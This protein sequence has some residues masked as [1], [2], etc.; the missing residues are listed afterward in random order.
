MRLVVSRAVFRLG[1]GWSVVAG[2]VAVGAL[3]L[4]AAGLLRVLTA[5]VLA[6]LVWGAIRQVIPIVPLDASLAT[7]AA[8]AA[9]A[10]GI[11]PY[12]Q[13]DAPLA[14]WLAALTPVHPLDL[15]TIGEQAAPARAVRGLTG[16]WQG[17]LLVGGLALILS[18]LLGW[19]AVALTL[20]ALATIW[21]AAAT[22]R[23]GELPALAHALLDVGWPWL[24]GM[25]LAAGALLDTEGAL[26][27]AAR[28]GLLLAAAFTVLQWG[29]YRGRGG[30]QP[31][32]AATPALAWLGQL[33]VLI[34]LIGLRSP[35]AVACVAALLAA[36]SFWLARARP[37]IWAGVTPW[38]WAASFVAA[39]AVR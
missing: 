36:P 22:A 5:A 1:P 33:V 17:V 18:M 37:D 23:R 31:R 3:E 24:L 12:A 35:W 13:P 21:T 26:W 30:A 39:F 9:P 15:V 19:P 14:R 4:D 2:A 38:W 34:V 28:P 29:M 16:A 10:A 20:I 11:L 8:A 25:S 27:A 7:S 32:Q 6:D